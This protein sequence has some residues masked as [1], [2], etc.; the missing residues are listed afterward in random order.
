MSCL[1]ELL[2]LF[3][4]FFRIG[5]FTFGGGYAMLPMLEKEVVQKYRWATMEELMDYFAIGQCTPGIIAVNTATFVGYKNKG[6]VGGIVATLGVIT[7]SLIIISV[8]ASILSAVYENPIV[9][10]A[11]AGIGVAVCAILIQAIIKLGKAGLVDKVTWI[12]GIIAFFLSLV[13][14]VSTIAIILAAG[15]IGVIYRTIQRRKNT[16]KGEK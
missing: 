4:A 1:K 11:F 7:P 15:V 9:Q 13:F 2:N 5:A 6:I 10:H 3:I 12:V 14:G 16:Q 8:I